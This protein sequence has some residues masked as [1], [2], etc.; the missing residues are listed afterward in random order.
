M[1]IALMAF[2]L[3]S[4][5]TRTK[6]PASIP[7]VVLVFAQVFLFIQLILGGFLILSV[8][9]PIAVAMTFLPLV[10][11]WGIRAGNADFLRFTVVFEFVLLIAVHGLWTSGL[12]DRLRAEDC[13]VLFDTDTLC[14][15]SWTTFLSFCLLVYQF[16]LLLEIPLALYINS[17]VGSS[18]SPEGRRGASSAEGGN[19]TST[20]ASKL[21]SSA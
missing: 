8:V 10:A 9:A 12:Y 14:T 16:S 19:A 18:N 7:R 20:E 13:T 17:E 15:D 3:I 4:S 6:P 1:A 11:L 5:R 21:L 2:L